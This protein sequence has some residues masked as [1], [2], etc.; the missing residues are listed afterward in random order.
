MKYRFLASLSVLLAV[1]CGA[2]TPSP[3]PVSQNSTDTGV[4]IS[5]P[6]SSAVE[7]EVAEGDQPAGA[8]AAADEKLVSLNVPMS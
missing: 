1:G 2:P 4:E 3:V 5:I 7:G 6:D 8:D